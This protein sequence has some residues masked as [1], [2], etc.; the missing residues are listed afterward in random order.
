M[1]KCT[2]IAKAIIYFL[3]ETVSLYSLYAVSVFNFWSYVL[4]Y[5]SEIKIGQ[6]NLLRILIA[7]VCIALSLL[8]CFLYKKQYE[9][10]ELTRNKKNNK[11]VSTV[12]SVASIAVALCMAI[13]Y[14]TIVA[15]L[16][17]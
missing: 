3:V 11:I 13:W 9:K 2:N 17:L 5:N 7:V 14:R 6:S 8:H 4:I 16:M 10:L 15:L 1:K 12:L